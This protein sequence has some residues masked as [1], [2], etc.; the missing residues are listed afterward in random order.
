MLLEKFEVISYGAGRR[1]MF[2]DG[3]VAEGRGRFLDVMLGQEADEG[4]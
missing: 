2:A 1:G 3:E 4:G